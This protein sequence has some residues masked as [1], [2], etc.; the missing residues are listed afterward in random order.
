MYGQ[1]DE[2]NEEDFETEF[3]PNERSIFGLILN[4][5]MNVSLKDLV[6]PNYHDTF[7]YFLDH[8]LFLGKKLFAD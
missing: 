6:R 3:P 8:P 7:K 1:L 2:Q 4:K 5:P